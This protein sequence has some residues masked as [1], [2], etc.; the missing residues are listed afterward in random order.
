[1]KIVI[2]AVICLIVGA[3]FGYMLGAAVTVKALADHI[4]EEDVKHDEGN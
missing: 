1:M 2:I 3:E 4:E